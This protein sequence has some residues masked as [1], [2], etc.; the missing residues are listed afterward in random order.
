MSSVFVPERGL[1]HAPHR[2][3]G[4][5][6]QRPLL[7][8]AV[9]GADG[10]DGRAQQG[11]EPARLRGVAEVRLG[12][13]LEQRGAGAVEVDDRGPTSPRCGRRPRRRASSSRRPPPGARARSTSTPRGR[14][15]APG[16]QRFVVL[17]DLVRLRA[18]RDR[19]SS[20]G[21]TSRARGSRSPAPAHADR[22][23]DGLAVRDRQHP[24]VR[25]ADRADVGVRRVAVAVQAAAEHLRLVGS[26]TWISRPIT[27]SQSVTPPPP[28]A[29]AA[30]G[31][32]RAP[33][34]SRGRRQQAVLGEGGADDL[35]ADRQPSSR[36]HGIDRPGRPARLTGSV[37]M[38]FAYIASG[39]SSFS[40][41]GNATDGA[42]GRSSASSRSNASAKSR[43]ISVRTRCACP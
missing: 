41:I 34:R 39:S 24:G 17:G 14:A 26:W 1:A 23:V 37:K 11:Q 40:P 18:C 8:V 12:D 16:A 25:Q 20:S 36:P 35:E 21:P 22:L 10:D 6:A 15:R 42:V 27:G 9:R 19:S 5:A 4:V 43:R 31:R 30:P 33:A 38:S 29:A 7:H 2:H 28:A 3:V 32:T 13:D